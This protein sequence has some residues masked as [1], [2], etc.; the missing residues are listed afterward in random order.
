M[1]GLRTRLALALAFALAAC[2]VEEHP[3]SRVDTSGAVGLI[4]YSSP[5]TPHGFLKVL[6]GGE[7]VPAATAGSTVRWIPSINGER[8]G[9]LHDYVTGRLTARRG[10]VLVEMSSP[11][12]PDSTYVPISL[13]L[14]PTTGALTSWEVPLGRGFGPTSAPLGVAPPSP[15]FDFDRAGTAYCSFLRYDQYGVPAPMA[16]INALFDGA[17]WRGSFLAM[18]EG[19]YAVSWAVDA[20]GQLAY[21]AC[22]KANDLDTG[23]TAR[24]LGVVPGSGPAFRVPD[25]GQYGDPW[26]AADGRIYLSHSLA[27]ALGT[28]ELYRVDFT[29]AVALTRTLTWTGGLGNYVGTPIAMGDSRLFLLNGAIA[30]VTAADTAPVLHPGLGVAWRELHPTASAICAVTVTDAAGVGVGVTRWTRAGTTFPLPEGTWTDV[31]IAA[32]DDQVALVSGQRRSDGSRESFWLDASGLITPSG[33]EP[34]TRITASTL[35]R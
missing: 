13:L 11:S 22:Q 35:F 31:A 5:S 28:F 1:H 26:L 3:L 25:D 6:P 17:A 19:D 4:A 12:A 30:E 24:V 32:I 10:H 20:D 8:S 23:C 7:I 18:P 21:R 2:A 9:P 33:L 29:P 14:D 34:G 16:V 27:D 15:L